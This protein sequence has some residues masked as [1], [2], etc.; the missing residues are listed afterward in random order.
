MTRWA[1][2]KT[3]HELRAVIALLAR[4]LPLLLL[5]QIVL[6]INTEMWQVADGFAAASS[7]SSSGCSPRS[8]T[9]S[10]AHG[11]P[12]RSG[13]SARSRIRRGARASWR[14]PADAPVGGRRRD[15]GPTALTPPARQRAA[16]RAVQPRTAG[17]ARQ[18]H[19]RCVLRP[20]RRPDDHAR[21]RRVWI[22]HAGDVVVDFELWGTP[23]VVTEQLLKLGRVPRGLLGALLLGHARDRH[24]LPRGVL[25]RG[26][27]GAAADLRRARGL[28]RPQAGASDASA[29]PM[30]SRKL[31]Q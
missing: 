26:G 31:S 5:I 6:F 29:E 14:H 27:R 24:D 21:G 8:G 10:C 28:P 1:L 16:R 4:A 20:L 22:G 2:A 11:F 25:R 18:R 15:R 9:A 23:V 13:G 12:A 30:R 19:P 7:S 17:P 3:A